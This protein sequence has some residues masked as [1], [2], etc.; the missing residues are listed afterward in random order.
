VEKQKA[1]VVDQACLLV[2]CE[3]RKYLFFESIVGFGN[4]V[5]EIETGFRQ[6]HYDSS[7]VCGA[8][9]SL[10]KTPFLEAVY[11]VGHGAGGDHGVRDK[12]TGAELVGR[13]GA[14]E[15][16]QHVV[17]PILETVIVEVVG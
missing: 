3:R 14:A 17:H 11:A 1:E 4:G 5:D 13:S 2:G 10:Y 16:G 6:L 8:V 15:R 7:S 9:T 12:F